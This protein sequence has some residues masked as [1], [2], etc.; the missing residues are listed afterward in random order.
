MYISRSANFALKNI[1]FQDSYFISVQSFRTRYETKLPCS[2]TTQGPFKLSLIDIYIT[3]DHADLV[4][5]CP[6]LPSFRHAAYG[7]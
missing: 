6:I 1:T 2:F 7:S 4:Y 3:T 5:S